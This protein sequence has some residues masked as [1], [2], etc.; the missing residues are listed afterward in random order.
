MVSTEL[1]LLVCPGLVQPQRVV[2]YVAAMT[3]HSGHDGRL[4][5]LRRALDPAAAGTALDRA[6][7]RTA[8]GAW[9]AACREDGSVPRDGTALEAG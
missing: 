1:G 2:E 7:F 4:R 8:M 5:A 9:I 6:R 3:G